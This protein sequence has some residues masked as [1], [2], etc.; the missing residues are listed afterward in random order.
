MAVVAVEVGVMVVMAVKEVTFEITFEVTARVL[1]AAMKVR[2][3]L[4]ESAAVKI[5]AVTVGVMRVLGIAGEI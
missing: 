4:E 5:F 1:V 2:E 3:T